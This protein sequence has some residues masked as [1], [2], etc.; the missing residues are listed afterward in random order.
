MI[1]EKGYTFT[2]NT[3]NISF[4]VFKPNLLSL[5]SLRSLT[6]NDFD[7]LE[8]YLLL[9]FIKDDIFDK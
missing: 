8:A 2:L 1:F 7:S 4:S 9:F 5:S 3:K 6:V